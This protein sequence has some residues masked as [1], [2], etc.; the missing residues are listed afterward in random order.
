M[1][2]AESGEWICGREAELDAVERLIAD[3]RSVP[4][5]IVVQGE[6]GIGKTTLVRRGDGSRVGGRPA[7]FRRQTVRR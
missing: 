6:A 7:G 2:V 3:A 4:A 5:A 1:A